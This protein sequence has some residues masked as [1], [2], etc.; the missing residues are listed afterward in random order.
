MTTLVVEDGS[1]LAS[2]N[3]Y[4]SLADAEAYHAA[5]GRTDWT[6]ED[7][8]SQ[9]AALIRA[10]YDLDSWFRGR[11]KGVQGTAA[12]ARSTTAIGPTAKPNQA[13]AWPRQRVIDEEG[14]LVDGASVPLVVKNACAE[15]AFIEL[16]EPFIQESVDRTN[17]TLS[18]RAGPVAVSYN[19]AAPMIKLYP[20]I[21]AMLRGVA[22]AGGV[23]LEVHIGVTDDEIQHG[24]CISPFN[25]PEYFEIVKG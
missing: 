16:T 14:Y 23:Q 12:T 22:A 2:A 3:S 1:G 5:R 13:L 20:H 15:I 17:A 21:D 10:T 18:E 19:T 6:D 11:W 7:D 24:N 8:D 4:I 9:I 25:Y